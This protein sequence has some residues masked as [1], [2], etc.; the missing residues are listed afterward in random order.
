MA[1]QHISPEVT[2]KCVKKCCT[3]NAVDENDD[4]MLCNDSEENENVRSKCEGDEGI[5]CE[6]ETV[7]LSGKGR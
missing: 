7:T 6:M 4:N 1:C 2:V 3:F 5:D